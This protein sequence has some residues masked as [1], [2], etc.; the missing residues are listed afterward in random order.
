MPKTQIVLGLRRMLMPIWS[1]FGR[2]TVVLS[3]DVEEVLTRNDIFVVPFGVEMARLN[4]GATENGT[5]FIL[6]MDNKQAHDNQLK[7]VMA[8]FRYSATCF[9]ISGAESF[10]STS[11]T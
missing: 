9:G 5:P 6:G 7:T 11:T 10:S 8:A 2:A 1:F 4:G 3:D